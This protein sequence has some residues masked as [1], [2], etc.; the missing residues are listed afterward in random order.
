MANSAG[1]ELVDVVNG[2]IVDWNGKKK[3][4]EY[5]TKILKPIF[6]EEYDEERSEEMME[7][8]V[9]CGDEL[10][11][12]QDSEGKMRLFQ[13]FFCKN[14][15]CPMCMWRKSLK[16]GFILSQVLTEFKK[17]YPKS[18]L[19]FVTLTLND[20]GIYDA[21]DIR[22]RVDEL[23]KAAAKMFRNKKLKKYVLGKVKTVETTVKRD[24]NSS[25]FLR[26]HVHLHMMIAV[27]ASYFS[28]GYL[29]K[30]EWVKLWR[31]SAEV[32][33][34]PSVFVEAVKPKNQGKAIQELS[35][36]M[37]KSNDYLHQDT[38][39]NGVVI[40]DENNRKALDILMHGL[41]GVN[42]I[43]YMGEFRKIKA[44]IK[45]DEDDLVHLSGEKKGKKTVQ[46]IY[47][48]Y[49]Q[50]KQKYYV[51]K[52]SGWQEIDF[53]EEEKKRKKAKWIKQQKRKKAVPKKYAEPKTLVHYHGKP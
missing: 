12:Y 29:S 16:D 10:T 42:S 49:I 24:K 36:Y 21:D 27:K 37:V 40:N 7:R 19:L 28:K 18:R 50:D 17:K 32:E 8:V 35:K 13:C 39:E 38:F 41:K 34:D 15:Y 45:A 23:N 26:F 20:T 43:T 5:F 33:Y 30:M 46:F 6:D 9:R 47:S 48:R 14:R 3:S 25:T 4:N 44:K 2:K 1:E 11:H 22:Q 53:D 52:R 51:Y 31:N